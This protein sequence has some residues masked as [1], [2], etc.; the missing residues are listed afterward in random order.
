MKIWYYIIIKMLQNTGR[1]SI[2]KAKMQNKRTSKAII[3]YYVLLA[4][5]ILLLFGMTVFYF[6]SQKPYCAFKTHDLDAEFSEAREVLKNSDWEFPYV[7]LKD[8]ISEVYWNW[9]LITTFPNKFG[10]LE[11]CSNEN[12]ERKLNIIIGNFYGTEIITIEIPNAYGVKVIEMT[13]EYSFDNNIILKDSCYSAPKYIMF[14]RNGKKYL[15]NESLTVWEIKSPF[16]EM[17]IVK[18][19]KKLM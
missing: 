11:F 10:Y 17:K 1:S 15:V 12:E 4:I 14:Y 18:F 2:G 7:A 6:Q 19:F 8:E 9:N 16:E 13:D 3:I 5:N